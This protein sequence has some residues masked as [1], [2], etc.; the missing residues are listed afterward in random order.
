MEILANF[1]SRQP[2]ATPKKIMTDEEHQ[3]SN[4]QVRAF[5]CEWEWVNQPFQKCHYKLPVFSDEYE[6]A[7]TKVLLPC[8]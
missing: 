6:L 1:F 5:N 4:F 7:S 3:T 8:S 2:H